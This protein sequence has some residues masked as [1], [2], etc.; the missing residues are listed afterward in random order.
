MGSGQKN[1]ALLSGK[2]QTAKSPYCV[3][4]LLTFWFPSYMENIE[5]NFVEQVFV[6]L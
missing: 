2:L 3:T 4:N 1:L 5:K 6:F